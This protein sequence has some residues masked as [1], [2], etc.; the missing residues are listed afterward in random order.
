M[1]E[2][3]F[4]VQVAVF[5]TVGMLREILKKYPDDTPI[6]INGVPGEVIEE[7]DNH[8][9]SLEALACDNDDE[10]LWDIESPAM[11]GADYMDF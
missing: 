1:D 2:F 6:S 4:G 3:D 7:D 10:G 11:V 5:Y 8:S 9:I